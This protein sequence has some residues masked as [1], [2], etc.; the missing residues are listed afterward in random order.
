MSPDTPKLPLGLIDGILPSKV[1]LF[2]LGQLKKASLSI[3][4]TYLGMV[5]LGK[6]EHPKNIASLKIVILGG[7]FIL[8]KFIHCW[9]AA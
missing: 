8:V 6:E 4:V 1:T 5:M 7:I 3:N 9:K 2:K